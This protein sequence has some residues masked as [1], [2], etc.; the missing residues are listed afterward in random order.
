MGPEG[1][2]E[3]TSLAGILQLIF[4]YSICQG[5]KLDIVIPS[6]PHFQGFAV[7]FFQRREAAAPAHCCYIPC[8]RY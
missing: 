2:E 7:D 8:L 1:W 5:S 3:E 4:V 6:T